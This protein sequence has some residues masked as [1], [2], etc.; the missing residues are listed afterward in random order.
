M[1]EES[2]SCLLEHKTEM[3]YQCNNFD[4]DKPK[5]YTE[6]RIALAKLHPE[7]FGP[8][9][10]TI[11]PD[12]LAKDEIKEK[13]KAEKELISKG[14]NRIIEKI[15]EIRQNIS[16]AIVTLWKWSNSV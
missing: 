2:I 15:K 14:R 11:F 6:K 12:N 16:K 5:L 7:V 9:K 4:A 10:E 8:V 1:I 13:S 3:A